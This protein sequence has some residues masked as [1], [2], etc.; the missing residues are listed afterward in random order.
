[1]TVG[2]FSPL[3]PA[4]TGVADYSAALLNE[5]RACGDVRV[6]TPGDVNLYH[7]GNNPLH[8]GIYARAL[9]EPGVVVLHDAVLHHFLLGLLDRDAYVSEFVFNYGE[10]GRS[11]AEELW[12]ERNGAAQDT[13]YFEHAMVKRIAEA[14]RAVIVH[15]PGAAAIV[16]R[17]APRARVVE[18][19]HLFAPPDLPDEL[20]TRRWREAHGIS[21]QT[22]LFGIFGHLRESKRV[23]ATLRAFSEVRQD[24]G[25][26]ALLIAG[27]FVSESYRRA[28]APL[29]QTPGVLRVEYAPDRDFWVMASAVDACISLRYPGAGETSGITVRLMG[30][31][32][33]VLVT[34]G[35]EICALPQETCLAVDCGLAEERML[36]HYMV[37]LASTPEA[38]RAIGCRA[39][40]HIQQHHAPAEIA[41]RYWEVLCSC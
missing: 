32:K 16:A 2:F 1:M 8:A 40:A 27:R 18:I 19:P 25:N 41:R 38:A 26:A 29:L 3:P 14:S 23:A 11:L 34:A 30:L 21:P 35:L 36:K 33:P 12:R 5:L 37:W 15:N 4:P 20:A 31:G 13:R 7:V 39:A 17:H 28:L 10:C 6:N 24:L 9:R 22:F